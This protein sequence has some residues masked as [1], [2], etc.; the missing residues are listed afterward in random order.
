MIYLD[1]HYSLLHRI[2]PEATSLPDLQEIIRACH[3]SRIRR[4]DRYIQLCL[5]GGLSCVGER[6]LPGNTGVYLASRCG[7][8]DTSARVMHAMEVAGEQPKPLHFVNTLGN[9]AGFYLTQLLGLTGNTVV[10]SAEE[11]SF[12]AALA[13]ACIDLALGQVGAA[14]VGGFDEVTL[15]LASQRER[16]GAAHSSAAMLEGSHWLL[17]QRHRCKAGSQKTLL[18]PRYF[19]DLEQWCESERAVEQSPGLQLA[20]APSAQEQQALAGLAY[21]VYLP[22][23]GALAHGVWSGAALTALLDQGVGVHLAKAGESYCALS[24]THA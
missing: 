8:V 1:N 6:E 24:V 12:E 22:E 15:P 10:V 20:F 9:S 21:Q 19:T 17:L 2:D 7:A 11:L 5:A 23:N 18:P 14:L 13:H 16:L 4:I 3:G